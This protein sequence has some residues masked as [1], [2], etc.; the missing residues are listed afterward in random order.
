MSPCRTH[1]D[2]ADPAGITIPAI[3][4]AA[5]TGALLL[6]LADGRTQVAINATGE[7]AEPGGVGRA[8]LA[9]SLPGKKLLSLVLVPTIREIRDFYREM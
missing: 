6:P 8:E 1:A 5:K 2:N 9:R 4:V 3:F 7:V